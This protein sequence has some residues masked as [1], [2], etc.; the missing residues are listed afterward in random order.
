MTCYHPM[1]HGNYLGRSAM[2]FALTTLLVN[3]DSDRLAI[4]SDCMMNLFTQNEMWMKLSN[5]LQL[6]V[7][8]SDHLANPALKQC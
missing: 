8:N 7:A 6:R 4:P 3:T 1:R 2:G 5:A